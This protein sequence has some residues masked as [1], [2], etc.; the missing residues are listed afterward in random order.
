MNRQNT[1]DLN[2]FW[3]ISKTRDVFTELDDFFRRQ[4]KL[5]PMIRMTA[6]GIVSPVLTG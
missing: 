1:A 3:E 5:F 2:K 6:E 4:M